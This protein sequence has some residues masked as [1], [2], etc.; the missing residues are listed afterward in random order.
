MQLRTGLA[1]CKTTIWTGPN[2]H[3]FIGWVQVTQKRSYFKSMGSFSLAIIFNTSMFLI[4][5]KPRPRKKRFRETIEANTHNIFIRISTSYLMLN[6]Q[7]SC[8]N[9]MLFFQISYSDSMFLVPNLL[10]F[11]SSFSR[12]TISSE[13]FKTFSSFNQILSNNGYRFNPSNN[14]ERH[15]LVLEM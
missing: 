2:R 9:S 13:V 1:N 8:S 3:T 6:F 11:L 15:L 5:S 4:F 7:I 12:A 10:K 14:F